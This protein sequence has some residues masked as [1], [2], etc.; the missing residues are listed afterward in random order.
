[1][2]AVA[3]S[4]NDEALIA[5]LREKKDL[6]QAAIFERVNSLGAQLLQR[7][8]GKLSGE[9]LNQRTGVLLRS[10]EWQAAEYVGAVCQTSVGIDEGQPSFVYA[11][12]HEYGGQG[13]Y[14]IAPDQAKALAFE[15][16]EGMIFAGRVNHPPAKETSYLRSSLDEMTDEIYAQLQETV[17][18]VLA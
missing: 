18:G 7:V 12:V 6:L 8:Q 10:V 16:P 9:V 17:S 1:M 5:E 2:A 4:L 11:Y 14:T 15:G 3:W 13:Y